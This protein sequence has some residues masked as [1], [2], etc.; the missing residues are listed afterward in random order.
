MC[1]RPLTKDICATRIAAPIASKIT[2]IMAEAMT[3]SV[4]VNP[5]LGRGSTPPGKGPF[6]IVAGETLLKHA[7]PPPTHMRHLC[8]IG[9]NLRG[10]LAAAVLRDV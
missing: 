2:S 6:S 10:R 1:W 8:N 5:P 9:A 4:K 3:T 7:R